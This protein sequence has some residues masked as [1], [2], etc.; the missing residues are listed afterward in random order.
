MLPDDDQ[1]TPIS[2]VFPEL[3]DLDN[4]DDEQRAETFS[5]VLQQLHTRLDEVTGQE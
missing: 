5:S 1:P 3:S 4:R 2:E